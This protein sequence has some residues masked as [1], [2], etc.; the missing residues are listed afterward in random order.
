MIPYTPLIT[1]FEIKEQSPV[2]KYVNEDDIVVYIKPTQNRWINQ[3]LSTN[4]YYDIM[5]KKSNNT[6]SPD[7]SD[8]LEIYIKPALAWYVAYNVA[9][10]NSIKITNKGATAQFSENSQAPNKET[11]SWSSTVCKDEADTLADMLTAYL[12]DNQT[13]FPKY[14]EPYQG[15]NQN[16][17]PS[18][19][20]NDGGIF[21][22]F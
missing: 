17:P 18:G 14:R 10:I 6:L 1:A 22:D 12:K 21:L 7:E 4:L 15:Q 5:S 16:I 8:L 9:R 11:I 19:T 13:L 20:I 3:V 2:L